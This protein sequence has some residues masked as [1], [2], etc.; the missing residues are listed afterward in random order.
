MLKRFIEETNKIQN[1][2]D[3]LHMKEIYDYEDSSPLG[4]IGANI[5]KRVATYKDLEQHFT[6]EGARRGK[7]DFKPIAKDKSWF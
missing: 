3:F 1:D 6:S 5:A 7:L 4:Q 2:K